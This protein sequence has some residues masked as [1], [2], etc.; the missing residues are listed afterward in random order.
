MGYDCLGIHRFASKL[1]PTNANG[2]LFDLHVQD[3]LPVLA[4][5]L[6]V[7]GKALFVDR[8]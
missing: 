4:A 2:A 5:L 3:I 1:A 8:F 7:F 6:A